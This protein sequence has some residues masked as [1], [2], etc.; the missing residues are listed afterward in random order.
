MEEEA[1]DHLQGMAQPSRMLAQGENWLSSPQC[2]GM[3]QKG[4]SS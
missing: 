2:P 1:V 3:M 4:S